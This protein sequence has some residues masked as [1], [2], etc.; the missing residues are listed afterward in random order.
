MKCLNQTTQQIAN[1]IDSQKFLSKIQNSP[2]M[3]LINRTSI[4]PSFV[5]VG[6]VRLGL[7]EE[8]RLG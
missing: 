5:D 6:K 3:E 4:F 7:G 2:K 8:V 1:K